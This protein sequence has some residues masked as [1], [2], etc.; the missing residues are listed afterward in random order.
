MNV[1]SRIDSE[2]AVMTDVQIQNETMYLGTMSVAKRLLE[3]GIISENE[4][5]QID[6]NFQ[7]KYGI[8]LSTLFT[9]IRLI[10][11]GSYGNIT[12]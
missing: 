6:T 4:Y 1:T 7:Q 2:V 5:A 12:H 11:F 3:K 9:D 8:S 10:K